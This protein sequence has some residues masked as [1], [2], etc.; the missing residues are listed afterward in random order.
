[1][2]TSATSRALAYVTAGYA[3]AF[4]DPNRPICHF[5]P[6]SKWM[7]DPN[8][9]IFHRGWFHLFYQHNPFGDQW[10]FMH[11]GHARSHDLIHWE[12]LPIALAPAVELGEE[13]CFS[14][15]IAVD[16]EG[17]PR[18][19][20]TSVPFNGGRYAQWRASPMDEDL[21]TWQRDQ[22]PVFPEP[23][24]HGQDARD[25]FI[26]RHQGRTFLIYG[27]AQGPRSTIPLW[28][29]EDGDLSRLVSRGEFFSLPQAQMPFCECPNVLPVGD[30][31][32]LLLSP[33]RAV[34]WRLGTFDGQ[35]FV[36]ERLGRLDLHDHFYA[37]NT[38]L[39]EQGRI[40]VVGWIRGF[41]IGTG[42]NGCLALPRLI[43]PDAVAGIRQRLHPCVAGLRL[44]VPIE[45]SGLLVGEKILVVDAGR[46]VE[47]QL[48][49][50]G[51][52]TMRLAGIPLRW[53][54]RFLT[55]GE[56]NYEVLAGD[57]HI[58]VDRT[59]VEVFADA[60]RTVITQVVY[61]ADVQETAVI[62]ADGAQITISLQRLARG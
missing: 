1:M 9:T 20:Y 51:A 54:G 5:T 39:D 44:G 34:E 10:G 42:W 36:E 13:H 60:G 30:K 62:A 28:E 46:T 37:T 29:A 48:R 27:A 41:K 6:P 19:F 22:M 55:V 17:T 24:A 49:S 38:L 47:V 25:P 11:W 58:I 32:L 8:G 43:E 21:L 4:A 35:R 14:G 56:G 40:V 52:F 7:N 45:W 33:F 61:A 12:H 50:S 2:D 57:F 18:L 23:L 26:F 59:T 16:H 3:A 53:D 31:M 15:C